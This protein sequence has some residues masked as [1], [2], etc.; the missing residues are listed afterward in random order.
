[1]SSKKK[2]FTS[3]PYSNDPSVSIESAGHFD[4][5]SEL[6]RSFSGPG[7]VR[8]EFSCKFELGFVGKLLSWAVLK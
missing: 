2:Y 8:F 7:K 6:G 4:R 1:M 5:D 3:L